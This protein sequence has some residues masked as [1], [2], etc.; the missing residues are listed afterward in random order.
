[1]YYT[2]IAI[3]DINLSGNL[4]FRIVLFQLDQPFVG[5]IKCITRYIDYIIIYLIQEVL[6][7]D[8]LLMNW[9]TSSEL[10]NNRIFRY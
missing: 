2:C 3:H 1:M 7:S 6:N 4:G 8:K 10:N 5:N 9:Q